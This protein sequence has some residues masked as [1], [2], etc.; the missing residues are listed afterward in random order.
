LRRGLVLSLILVACSTS[1]AAAQQVSAVIAASAR[2][3]V[4]RDPGDI[5][6]R[7][8]RFGPGSEQFAP[9]P[10]FTFVAE[11]KLGESP[12]LKVRDARGVNWSVKLGEEAQ[13]E[14]VAARLV[15]AMGY[16][17]EESYY[18]SRAQVLNLPRLSRGQEYVEAGGVV[19]SVRFEPRREGV[20]RGANWDWEQNPFAGTRELNGLKVMMV[21]LGNYDTSVRNNRIFTAGDAATG[22]LEDRYVVSDVGATLGKVGGLGGRRSKN[23]LED[24]RASKFVVGVEDGVVKFDYSTKPKGMGFFAS[25]FS[26]GYHKSQAKKE[27]AMKTAPVADARWIGSMLARLSDEQLRDAFR[28]AG[29]DS[30]TMEGYVAALRGRITQLAQLP[31]ASVASAQNTGRSN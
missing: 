19:R 26:P 7:D 2:P 30:A 14:T 6:A 11:D 16:F 5:S 9:A 8:L 13:S 25:V 1:Y 21:L 15:W 29:Y 10:P 3:V 4:W 18:L 31:A 28:A 24:F 27:R 17:A 20:K 22:A 23:S 12:K